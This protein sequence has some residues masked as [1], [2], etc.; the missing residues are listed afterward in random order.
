MQLKS[1]NN[2]NSSVFLNPWYPRDLKTAHYTHRLHHH[3]IQFLEKYP[4]ILD[5]ETSYY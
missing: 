3:K 5:I 4:E 1:D 2:S